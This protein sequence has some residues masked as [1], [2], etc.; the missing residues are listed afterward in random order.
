MGI[1]VGFPDLTAAQ[2]V[3][4]CN[5]IDTCRRAL[6]VIELMRELFIAKEWNGVDHQAKFDYLESQFKSLIASIE[7]QFPEIRMER[8]FK[9]KD[10]A[11][12][13]QL[14]AKCRSLHNHLLGFLMLEEDQYL[15]LATIRRIPASKL[16]E[17]Q[18]RYQ[19][20]TAAEKPAVKQPAKKQAK[21]K[22]GGM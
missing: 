11:S 22:A 17:L 16:N 1:H 14:N 18:K 7:I 21:R 6:T 8:S 13:Q 10:F 3:S 12:S 15:E 19:S 9:S 4:L 5:S 2:R 20:P